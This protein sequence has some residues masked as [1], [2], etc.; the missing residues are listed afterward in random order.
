MPIEFINLYSEE[1][2]TWQTKNKEYNVLNEY[3][4][5]KDLVSIEISYGSGEEKKTVQ[6]VWRSEFYDDLG[7]NGFLEQLDDI[8]ATVDRKRGIGKEIYPP[9]DYDY[10][11]MTKKEIW[12]DEEWTP[13]ESNPKGRWWNE[14]GRGDQFGNRVVNGESGNRNDVLPDNKHRTDG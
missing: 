1:Q 10:N 8:K 5:E 7:S 4:F 12:A 6:R 11:K 2:E 3:F 9:D 14:G 13:K